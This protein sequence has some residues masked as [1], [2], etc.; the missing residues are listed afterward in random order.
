MPY[1]HSELIHVLV[2]QGVNICDALSVPLLWPL[3]A[4]TCAC[5]SVHGQTYQSF[6]VCQSVKT[7][8]VAWAPHSIRWP[9]K[10][11]KWNAFCW[12]KKDSRTCS[13]PQHPPKIRN[14]KDIGTAVPDAETKLASSWMT[15]EVLKLKV[16]DFLF[17][18]FIFCFFFFF[19]WKKQSQNFSAQ[20]CVCKATRHC[21]SNIQDGW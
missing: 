13:A 8:P 7:P 2:Y 16:T 19:K 20:S 21:P 4:N 17:L 14:L 15:A 18:S 12:N 3:W 5:L 10:L 11:Q 9:A 1:V 6:T